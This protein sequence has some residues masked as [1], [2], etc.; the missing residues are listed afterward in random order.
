MTAHLAWLQSQYEQ[1]PGG[2][3]TPFAGRPAE[4]V[5]RSDARKRVLTTPS[6]S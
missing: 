3:V 1:K 2:I 5:T 6:L 4:G